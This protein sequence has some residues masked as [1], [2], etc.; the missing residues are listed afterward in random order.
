MRMTPLA[1]AA[2]LLFIGGAAQAQSPEDGPLKLEP[3]RKL[4]PSPRGDAARRLP[5]ILRAQEI[6]ARPDLEAVADGAVEFRRGG[7]SINADRLSYDQADDLASARGHVRVARDGAIYSGPELQLRVQR[8]EGFFLAPEFEFTE[9]GA[10]GRADRVDF[11]DASRAWATNAIYTSCPRD[12]PGMPDWVLETRRVKLDFDTNEGVA[13]GAVLRFLGTPILALPALSFPL[14]DERKSGW[15]PPTI[16]PVDS[17]NGT[18]F[19]MPYYWNIAPN[20]DA[21]IAPRVLLRR[22][23]GVDGEYRYLERSDNGMLGLQ[24]LPD[25][26]VANRSRGALQWRH[27]GSMSSGW[28]YSADINRVSDDGWWKDFPDAA[29]GLTP[30]LLSLRGAVERPFSLAVGEGLVYL[31]AQQWQALQGSDVLLSPPYQRS[32]QLGLRAS[33]AGAGFELTAETELNR[34]T[35]PDGNFDPTRITGQRWHALGSISRPWREPGAWLVPKLSFNAATYRTDQPLADGRQSESRVIPSFSI[36]TGLEFERRSAGFGRTFR[37]TLEPRLLYVLT[38]YRAQSQLPNFDAAEK[39]FNFSSIYSENAF[40]GVDRVSDAHQVTAGVTSRLVDADTGAEALRMG[41]VQRFLFRDQRVTAKDDGTP[42]GAPLTQRFSD[43]LLLA[44]THLVQKWTLDA[45][46]QYSPDIARPVR[47]IIGARYSPGPLRTVSATYRYTRGLSEQLEVGWQW[48]L[49]LSSNDS[50]AAMA[51]QSGVGG[52]AARNGGSGGC[53]GSWYTVGRFNYSTKDRRFT[54]SILGA[55]YDAGCWIG[56]VVAER[57]STGR[58]EA[59][60][61]LLLQ[62]ELVGLS[63]IGS[64]PLKVLKDNIPGYRLLRDDRRLP[65]PT[66]E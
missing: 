29:R 3:S 12:A 47:S 14:S 9:F 39:D 53:G 7:L 4:Q 1:L 13:E 20:R 65:T 10:G 36:D 15:L 45:S 52:A 8:F 57:L 44:S 24:L 25:D 64:N 26:H 63:R 43:L 21:T 40:S 17:R 42:D 50:P 6:R 49:R 55:E 54:D 35:L 38:P 32:P 51:A 23:F 30:R 46:L 34:F 37:Q 60:T 33:G 5:I 2:G 56:R 31:R 22:G 19:S 59:S 61:R 11:L 62:L 28:R 16:V 58:S 48:P 27:E 66:D 41:L 18:T